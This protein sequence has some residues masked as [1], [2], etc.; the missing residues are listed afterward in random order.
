VGGLDPRQFQNQAQQL[1]GDTQ[2]FRRQLEAAGAERGD[3]QAVDEV[4][5]ALRA[6]AAAGSGEGTLA[7]LQSLSATALDKLKK[8][9]FELR[10][11]VD[12]TSD[13]LYLSSTEEVPDRYR[14]LVDDYHRELS[15]RT[16]TGT[17]ER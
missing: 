8:L 4:V 16:T 1:L 13:Q 17:S 15:R 6:M 11:R 7:N 5:R 3:I 12:T 10:Q 9:E 2:E 14:P